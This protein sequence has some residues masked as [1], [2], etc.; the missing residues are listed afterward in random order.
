MTPRIGLCL[1]LASVVQGQSNRISGPIGDSARVALSGHIDPKVAVAKDLGAV[2]PGFSVNSMVLLLKRSAEQQQALE[3]LLAE[4]RDPKSA[5]YHRWLSAV[6][7]ADRFGL[8]PEDFA[9]VAAWIEAQGFQIEHQAEA[10]NWVM[11]NGTPS[12]IS[13]AFHTEIHKVELDGVSHYANVSDPQIPLALRDVVS[14]I[15]GLHNFEPPPAS[16]NKPRPLY[17][18][19]GTA[20]LGPGDLAAA[21]DAV[22]LYNAGI[23]GEGISIAVIGRADFAMSDIVAYKTLFGLPLNLPQTVMAG[24]DPGSGSQGDV[25]EAELDLEISGGIAPNAAIKYVNSPSVI[26]S[27]IY[28]IDQNLA[29]IITYSYGACESNS[30]VSPAAWQGYIQEANAMGITFFASSGDVGPAVCDRGSSTATHGITMG[31]PASVPEVTSV[32]GTQI[33]GNASASFPGVHNE[34][35]W[36]EDGIYASST[37][38]PSSVFAKPSWQSGP[39]VPAD[40]KRDV[41]DIALAAASYP[42]DNPYA[43]CIE[44]ACVGGRVSVGGGTS[45]GSPLAAGILALV[46]QYQISHGTL[47]GPG[48]GNIN[49][50]L[51]QLVQN[52]P[53]AFRDVRYGNNLVTC[54]TGTPNCPTGGFGYNA[55]PG[56]DLVTGLGAWDAYYLATSWKAPTN[57]AVSSVSIAP[58]ATV[59]DTAVQP[60]TYV[61]SATVSTSAASLG[62]DLTFFSD[63]GGNLARVAVS[64]SGSTAM[65]SVSFSKPDFNGGTVYA[66]YSGDD[67]S[68]GTVSTEVTPSPIY[69]NPL[70]SLSSTSLSVMPG[71]PLLLTASSPAL[72]G[73]LSQTVGFVDQYNNVLF[74]GNQGGAGSLTFNA[75]SLAPGSYRIT[76]TYNGG[77][78]SN[79]LSISIADTANPGYSLKVMAGGN[80]SYSDTGDGGPATAA[81][82]QDLWSVAVDGNGNT[83]VTNPLCCIRRIDSAGIITTYATNANASS[84]ATAPDGT[85]YTISGYMVYKIVNGALVAVAGTGAQSGSYQGDGTPALSANIY[86]EAITVGPDGTLFI[87]DFSAGRIF[88]V[89]NGNLYTVAGGGQTPIAEGVAAR[90]ASFDPLRIGVDGGGLMYLAAFVGGTNGYF[91][92]RIDSGGIFHVLAGNATASYAAADRPALSTPFPNMSAMAVDAQGNVFV[93]DGGN[94]GESPTVWRISNGQAIRVA[95]NGTAG[96]QASQN[97]LLGQLQRPV[98]MTV[99]SKGNVYVANGGVLYPVL[100]LLQPYSA[101]LSTPLRFVPVTP[102]RVADTRSNSPTFGGTLAAQTSRDFPITASAC[103]I[104]ATAQAYSLNLTAVPPNGISYLSLWP[105]NLPQPFVSILNSD[106]RV[107]ANAAILRAGDNNSVSVYTTDTTDVVLDINGYFVPATNNSSALEFYPLTP[108]RVADTRNASG[109]LGGP[110]LRSGQTRTFP[111]LSSSCGIS[112]A[113]RA[114]SLNF[115]AV[116]PGG[117]GYLSTWPAG[118]A[119]P[120][121]STLNSPGAIVANAAIVPAGINGDIAVYSSDN[122]HVVID[123]D[124]YFAPA[125]SSGLS[126]YTMLPCRALDTRNPAGSAP[127]NGTI[128]ANLSNSGCAVPSSAQAFVMNATVV[129]PSGFGYLTLW[130]DLQTKPLVSTLNAFDGKI[131]SNLAIVPSANGSVDAFGSSP[132]YLILDLSGYFAP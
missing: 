23:K 5:N 132:V 114:Y 76:A 115:T 70:L 87:A 84:L 92:Y 57:R 60:E 2:D 12:Q 35:A 17:T 75:N 106:G 96:T 73:P 40:G 15:Q 125:S 69:P 109:P 4:Q 131:T 111:M 104:P 80:S 91:V 19:G 82:F 61:Y 14:G 54:T 81:T 21:Y 25:A 110:I 72:C 77:N 37:G 55:G 16:E 102:C 7:F 33:S 105:T 62:G 51:Y 113:A 13:S 127:F 43:T 108:C 97:A 18:N 64:S 10:R 130:P 29:P 28:A 38:G 78:S 3:T 79:T 85:L 101:T 99:D 122:T 66:V 86:P 120:V 129:P 107:K 58:T 112:S 100:Q 26:T 93:A 63:I 123:I 98:A 71:V 46:T 74:Q 47:S 83:F 95:G 124:G 121:V 22:P 24:A 67:G 126:L 27:A 119:Q 11:F 1:I 45:A 59:C 117:V 20:Y 39:G 53:L 65:V 128:I 36:N 90:S 42:A 118:S 88:R 31:L 116:P 44:G 103:G 89:A 6:Q 8:S 52:Y 49:P 9:K 32:G 56:Y 48:L 50:G 30:T 68:L 41:P 34:V 94:Y